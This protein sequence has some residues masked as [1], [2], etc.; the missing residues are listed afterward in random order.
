[1]I[2]IGKLDLTGIA[3]FVLS[4]LGGVV[5]NL[6]KS[7]WYNRKLSKE[8]A[9]AD[10]AESDFKSEKTKTHLLLKKAEADT[11]YRKNIKNITKPK[12]GFKKWKEEDSKLR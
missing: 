3:K 10:N 5:V 9:R 4:S 8:T 12:E 11:R 6:V 1:M 2:N 7:W